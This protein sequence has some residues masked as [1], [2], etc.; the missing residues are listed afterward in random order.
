MPRRKK[1]NDVD[2][3]IDVQSRVVEVDPQDHKVRR[4]MQM[5]PGGLK[6]LQVFRYAP[7]SKGGRPTYIDDISP[8]QFDFKTM[9][10]MFGGGKFQV[11]WDNEDGSV[12]KG[13][14]D[15]AGPYINFD[16][17]PEVE[18]TPEPV[19]QPAVNQPVQPA[20]QGIDPFQL[21]Q[22]MQKAEERGEAR[23][24]KLLEF[25]RPQQQSPDVTKQ[26][27]EIVEKIA[28][29]MSG[30]DGGSPWM[31]ALTQ[32]KEPLLKIVDSVHAAL[33]RPPVPPNP[34]VPP[35]APVAQ[36]SLD[37][38][39]Q[40]SE[41]DML[42]LL[43]RQYLPVFVNAARNNGNPDIYA[44]MVLEQIP[45]SMYPK[46]KEWL[47]GPTWVQDITSIEKNIEFQLGW[48]HLLK[49]SLI[50]GIKENAV[51]DVQHATDSEHRED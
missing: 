27:F 5:M 49:S 25:M 51:G 32:F 2:D 1:N 4:L 18:R 8:E 40:P 10:S 31:V 13:D 29:M 42:K 7:G 24:M 43:I 11:K 44:D 16:S 33:T 12:S 17:Q 23:M 34:P 28:P 46:L 20:Q 41:D 14:F 48:W 6:C 35:K 37:Q 26:V 21:M 3:E 30:G 36:P 47:E 9:K 22:M 50:E 38:H 19:F 15:I 45:E 39:S